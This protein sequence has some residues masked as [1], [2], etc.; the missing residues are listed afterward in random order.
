MLVLWKK[1]AG[2]H[3]IWLLMKVIPLNSI[4]LIKNERKIKCT[5]INFR[6]IGYD[7]IAEILIKTGA[8]VNFVDKDDE[9]PLLRAIEKGNL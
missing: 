8:N 2:P 5:K 1:M 4:G 9:T 7:N 3:Y 6:T